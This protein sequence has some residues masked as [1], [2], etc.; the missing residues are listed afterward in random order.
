MQ[1][2]DLL[3]KV[4]SK[5]TFLDFLEALKN[6]KI[7]EDQK[8]KE[9]PSKPYSDGKNGWV[10]GSIDQ[11]LDSIRAY[12][13]ENDHIGLNWQSLAELFYAGKIYE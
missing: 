4:N 5:E 2:E 13:L 9:N 11:F 6:D 8:E 12:G 7:D 10:N 1:L 3:E